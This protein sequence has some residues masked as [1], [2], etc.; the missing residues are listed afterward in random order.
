[1]YNH[2]FGQSQFSLMGR[3]H[4]QTLQKRV[5]K[6]T[7]P[8]DQ[9]YQEY[10]LLRKSRGRRTF[11]MDKQKPFTDVWDFKVVQPY[12][13]KHPCEKPADMME[14]I[15]ST[16]SQE[17][18]VVLDT[19]V[20]SGST[21]KAAHKLHR[22]FIGCEFGSDEYSKVICDLKEEGFPVNL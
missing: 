1:M 5:P 15:I 8:Y 21:A 16:S 20:G 4:Y 14:H 19:F 11:N 18:D 10:A 7:K 12:K 22:N 3:D 2:W 6:F 17:G 9:L 13:G